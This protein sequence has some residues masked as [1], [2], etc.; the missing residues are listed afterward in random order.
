[1]L[2]EELKKIPAPGLGSAAFG[3]IHRGHQ[4]DRDSLSA[5]M[6]A[7]DCRGTS[8]RAPPPPT[9]PGT[10]KQLSAGL[11]AV[12]RQCGT[13]LFWQARAVSRAAKKNFLKEIDNSRRRL[14]CEV[15]DIYLHPLAHG[16]G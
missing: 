10:A 15:V 4:D 6:T 16:R 3:V 7:L 11:S 9:V 14:G 12:V 2:I 1:M 13:D 8:Y 5:L